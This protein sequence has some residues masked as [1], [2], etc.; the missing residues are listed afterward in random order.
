M[1][2]RKDEN[3]TRWGQITAVGDIILKEDDKTTST[4]C[5]DRHAPESKRATRIFDPQKY[6]L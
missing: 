6:I 1:Q 3:N 2:F 4:A 5:R